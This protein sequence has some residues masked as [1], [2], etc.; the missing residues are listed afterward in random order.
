MKKNQKQ[1]FTFLLLAFLVY[2]ITSCTNVFEAPIVISNNETITL[3]INGLGASRTIMPAVAVHD[4]VKFDLYFA[5]QTM[6]NT[7][8]SQTW[9]YS[10]GTVDLAAGIWEL[11]VIAYL[12]GGVNDAEEPVFLESAIKNMLIT[13][14][15]TKAVSIQLEPITNGTGVFNWDVSYPADVSAAM[16]ITRLDENGNTKTENPY[17]EI[18]AFVKGMP[19]NNTEIGLT[20]NLILEAGQYRV[21]FTLSNDADTVVLSEIL[22]VYGNM[23]SSFTKV[24]TDSIFVEVALAGNSLAEK[25]AW[26]QIN[27]KSDSRYLIAISDD[28]QINPH[29]L[30]YVNRSNITIRLTGIEDEKIISLSGNGSLFTIGIGVTLML[31]ENI[32]LQGHDSNNNS[33]IR[34]NGGGELVMNTG[35]KITGNRITGTTSSGGGVYV[36]SSGT[37]T[38][39]GGEISDNTAYLGGGGVYVGSNGA[40]TMS[41]GE[42]SGNTAYEGGGVHVGSN[43]TM[44]GGEISG[45]KASSGGGV[46]VGSGRIFRMDGGEISGNTASYGGGVSV[47]NGGT[48]TMNGGE[49]SGNTVSSHGGGGGVYVYS[50]GTFRITNGTIY[51]SDVPVG[52]LK[53]TASSGASLYKN[54][55]GI[56][57]YGILNGVT[58]ESN[59]NLAT[60]NNTIKVVNGVLQ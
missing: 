17:E 38:M 37:F 58:W 51:G 23:H 3:S 7:D 48:F 26:L 40:F 1:L 41:G 11:T 39:S 19:E 55:T 24:F 10:S 53:N 4:F 8:F 12:D 42:I 15:D 57:E 30:S 34:V 54:T 13:V 45:N 60:T 16:K 36:A 22:H 59:G 9:T 46:C 49:I 2:I 52:S 20:D 33:L 56:I 44:N 35:A 25:L 32:T 27:A 5:A 31:D 50:G 18:F 21:V 28:E 6:G 14:P 29:N 47:Y 43:F